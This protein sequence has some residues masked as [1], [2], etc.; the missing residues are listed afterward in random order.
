MNLLKA[1]CKVLHIGHKLT[2]LTFLDGSSIRRC[3]KYGKPIVL[4]YRQ[5]FTKK[6]RYKN[7]HTNALCIRFYKEAIEYTGFKQGMFAKVFIAHDG[8]VGF[9]KANEHYGAY[10]LS[11]ELI[12]LKLYIG[13]LFDHVSL[14]SGKYELKKEGDKFLMFPL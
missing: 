12:Y 2:G 8:T 11:K 10:K 7:T 3:K 14:P 6:G 9:M 5:T 13:K 1:L 4:V